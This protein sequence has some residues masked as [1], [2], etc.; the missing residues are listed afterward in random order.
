MVFNLKIICLGTSAGLP[1]KERNTQTTILSL[2][3]LYNEYWMFDCGEA[4]QHQILHTSIK[5]GRLTHIFISH[6]HGDH[7]FGLPGVLTSRSFQGGQDKKL[8]L[9]GPTGLKQFVDT[10]LTIS[11]SHLNYPLEIIEIDH[12]DEFVINDIEIT[13]GALK[14]GIPSFGYRIVMPDTAGNLIKEKLIAEGIAPG[15]VYKE[16]KLHE[17][18]TLNGKIYNTKDFKTAGKKGKKLVFFGDTM[19]CENEVSLA[20][21]ADIVV[22]EC[23]YL[24]GD[25]ELS[26]KYYHSHID[27]VLSLVSN[28]NV[29]KLI[30]N[31]VSNRYT[32]KDINR[33]LAEINT[34]TECE[35]FIADDFY[36]YDIE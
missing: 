21:N 3:P 6:L 19:P 27:D 17:Q 32:T 20:E 13:V 1:T 12:G 14:H 4:A 16:F 24:D 33:L 18:V 10:V 31:H 11:C 5:L 35:V 28:G 29:K 22:H 36:E 2:N 34:K 23:T 15:P 30:I 8:T 9:Y 25:I 7:I 26:H